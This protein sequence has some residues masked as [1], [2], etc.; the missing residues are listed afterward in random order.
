MLF[1]AFTPT[2]E[3]QS[4]VWRTWGSDLDLPQSN[5]RK[6]MRRLRRPRAALKPRT[7]LADDQ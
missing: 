1:A 6:Q 4:I 5:A 7:D 3:G 2:P